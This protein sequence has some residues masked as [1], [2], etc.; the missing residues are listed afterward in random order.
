MGPKMGL[1]ISLIGA[2]P[3]P[4]GGISIYTKQLAEKLAEYDLN[5]EIIDI[6]G[7]TKNSELKKIKQVFVRSWHTAEFVKA[8]LSS[9]SDIFHV[10]VSTYGVDPLYLMTALIGRFKRKK[11]M[12]TILGGGFVPLMESFLFRKLPRL[13][14]LNIADGVI[15]I[16]ELQ[17]KKVLQIVSPYQRD[18]VY[19]VFPAVDTERFNPNIDDR[20]VRRKYG[21]EDSRDL[22]MFGP[23]LEAI[24][25]PSQF[26]EAASKVIQKRANTTFMLLGVGTLREDLERQV[27]EQQLGDNIIFCGAVSFDDIHNYYAACDVYCNPCL[28]GQGISTFEA[29]ACGKPVIGARAKSQIRVRDKIDGLLFEPGNVEEF[30]EKVVWLLKK[31]EERRVMGA[32]GRKRVEEFHS[33][34]RQAR[35]HIEIYEGT[36]AKKWVDEKSEKNHKQGI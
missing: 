15:T 1:K 12:L 20:I 25:A 27:T 9:D 33:L 11:F 14:V 16:D 26:I 6:T 28:I 36:L 22:V 18:H 13:I 32:N 21:I 23:H 5:V 2:I 29:M 34:E 30:A 3:P 24:Y 8:L 4:V 31:P 19:F 35:K 17:H 7:V 10:H